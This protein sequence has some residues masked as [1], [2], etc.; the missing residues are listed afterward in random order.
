MVSSGNVLTLN[1][2]R[3]KDLFN[4]FADEANYPIAFHCSIGTDRTGLVA[5]LL[6]GVLG[7]SKED[8]YRDYIFSNFG[9]IYNMRTAKTIDEYLTTI[10][11]SSGD[12]LKDKFYNYLTSVGVSSLS[13]DKIKNIMIEKY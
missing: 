3:L 4:Y 13:L 10:E 2:T 9:L 12:K 1:K 5:F 6:N 8:L 11:A 7:V